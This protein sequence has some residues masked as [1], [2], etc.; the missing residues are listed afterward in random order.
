[1]YGGQLPVNA[2]EPG[3]DAGYLGNVNTSE[4]PYNRVLGDRPALSPAEI[5]DLIAFLCT[6][7][8]GYDPAHPSAQV[9]PAQCQRSSDP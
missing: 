5:D 1:V 7:T 9:L 4:I 2:T 8:D 6:L 3:S